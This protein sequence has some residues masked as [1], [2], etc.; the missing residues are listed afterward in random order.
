MKNPKIFLVLVLLSLGS[1]SGLLAADWT[2]Y[3]TANSGLISNDVRAICVDING[4]K[5]FG[6][7][8]GLVRFDG[9]SW[10][11]FQVS[12]TTIQTLPHNS[13]RDIAFEVTGY[14]PEIWVATDSGITVISV[15]LELDG[16]SMA[17]PYRTDNTGLVSN[18]VLTA[19]VDY[20]GKKWFA[21]DSGLASFSGSWQTGWKAYTAEDTISALSSSQILSVGMDTTGWKYIGTLGGG[22]SRLFDN[23][24]DA[25]SSASPY[26]AEWTGLLSDTIYAAYAT[27]ANGDTIQWFGTAY[28]AARHLGT[29]SKENWELLTTFE[30]LVNDTVQVIAEDSL[31]RMWFGTRGGVT[32]FQNSI[33]TSLTVANGLVDNDIRDIDFDRDGSVWLVTPKGISHFTGRLNSIKPVSRTNPVSRT[34]KLNPSYPNPFNSTTTISYELYTA[35]WITLKIFNTK[36][37]V[38]ISLVNGIQPAGEYRISWNGLSATGSELPSGIYFCRLERTSARGAFCEV[39]KMVLLK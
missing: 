24:V 5:W 29:K 14:G 39:Q 10:N 19:A 26:R 8:Q 35:G 12:D 34:F 15:P 11:T 25:V 6:T 32:V 2:N 30:G 17:T 38:V 18:R 27:I 3:T 36:G 13:I 21:T 22:V 28:G 16:I 37:Q 9:S 33:S 1:V 20:K 31:G 7:A 4:V 23:K